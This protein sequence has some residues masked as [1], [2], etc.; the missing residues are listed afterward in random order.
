MRR[1]S[2]FTLVEILVVLGIIALLAGLLFPVVA[3]ARLR[4]RDAQCMSQMRQ[5]L[6]A[7]GAYRADWGDQFPSEYHSLTRYARDDRVFMCPLACEPPAP[8]VNPPDS[9]YVWEFHKEEFPA[10]YRE[11]GETIPVIFCLFHDHPHARLIVMHP[12]MRI[13]VGRACGSVDVAR[14]TVHYPDEWWKL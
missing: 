6:A 12:D 8:C 7:V 3:R 4:A 5:L 1:K 2:G 14:W 10:H 11:R 9:R 13:F